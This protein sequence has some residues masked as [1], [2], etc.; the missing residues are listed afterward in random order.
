M[1]DNDGNKKEDSTPIALKGFSWGGNTLKWEYEADKL[2]N[3]SKNQ[4]ENIFLQNKDRKS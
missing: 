4:F 3:N 1:G 2:A